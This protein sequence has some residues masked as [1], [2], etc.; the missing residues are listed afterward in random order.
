MDKHQPKLTPRDKRKSVELITYIIRKAKHDLRRAVPP[1][2][3]VLGHEAL[4]L[5]LVEPAREPEIANLELAIRVHEQVTRLE[6]AMQHVGRVNVFQ[7]AECLIDEGLEMCVREGLT[8]TNLN[9]K[10]KTPFVK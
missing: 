8:R 6:I 5:S 3:D 4:L 2:R 10:K 7:T 9:G 1:R